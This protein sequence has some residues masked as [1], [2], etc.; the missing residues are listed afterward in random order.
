MAT[1]HDKTKGSSPQIRPGEFRLGSAASRAAARALLER[2]E[3]DGILI[4]MR[5]VGKTAV[6]PPRI[7][8]RPG[9]IRVIYGAGFEH[10]DPE[11]TEIYRGPGSPEAE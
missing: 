7:R 3:E 5:V 10:E 6:A 4:W 2:R 8:R 11:C 1:K 9:G